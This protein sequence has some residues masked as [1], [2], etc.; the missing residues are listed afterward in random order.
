M[1]Q[2]SKK[3]QYLVFLG[4]LKAMDNISQI[5][6]DSD[7]SRQVVM[8]AMNARVI[9]MV[10]P[11][12]D[13]KD[14]N[15]LEMQKAMH[16]LRIDDRVIGIMEELVNQIPKK[17]KLSRDDLLSTLLKNNIHENVFKKDPDQ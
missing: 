2:L 8:S 16:D 15:L 4:Y 1:T 10:Y 5:A 17:K 3:E 6:A 14:E 9:E 13:F 12:G 7:E 11:D